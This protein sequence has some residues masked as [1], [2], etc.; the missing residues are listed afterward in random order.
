[1]TKNLMN[2]WNSSAA[3]TYSMKSEW[4]K[5]GVGGEITSIKA[6]SS[7]VMY[8]MRLLD[9]QPTRRFL[10][11]EVAHQL[12]DVIHVVETLQ[13][14]LVVDDLHGLF[15]HLSGQMFRAGKI[16]PQSTSYNISH[17]CHCPCSK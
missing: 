14:P 9:F 3:L 16:S 15:D 5:Q 4:R 10:A 17:F 13:L 8:L 6:V 11:L 2:G 12:D 7:Q 1:M